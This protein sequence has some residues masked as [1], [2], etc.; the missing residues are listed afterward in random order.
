MELHE[1]ISQISEIRAH[2]ARTETFRGYRAL[3]VAVSG[4][5]AWLGAAAQMIWLP[6]PA[7]HLAAWLALWV[8]IAGVSLVMT[9]SEMWL[10]CRA[11]R[12]P[13]TVRLTRLAAEQFLPCVAAGALVSG[14][15]VAAAPEVLW[16]LPGVWA[17]LYG[18]GVFASCRLLPRP[19][20]WAGGYYLASGATALALA[21]GEWAFSPWAMAGTFGVGQFI[22]AA[23][24]YLALERK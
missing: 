10:R 16:I 22:I 24:L 13:W 2:L 8:A 6:A 18:L 1:A 19:L 14:V 23:V 4:A 5:L 17:V 20:A 11:S 21:R 15:L 3:T 12:S 7:E 9:G